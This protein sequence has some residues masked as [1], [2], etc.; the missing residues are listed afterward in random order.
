MRSPRSGCPGCSA[1]RS[2]RLFFAISAQAPLLQRWFS[3][4]SKGQDPYALY[5]ASN[6]GSFAGLIAYPLLVEPGLALHG[7]SR[8]WTFG[9]ILVVLLVA[10]CSMMLP[11]MKMA[12]GKTGR[13]RG[14]SQ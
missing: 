13:S 3:V 10:V 4:A 14:R 2:G 6:F 7:Q 9:Y 8:L 5:A 1:P 12:P 11:K